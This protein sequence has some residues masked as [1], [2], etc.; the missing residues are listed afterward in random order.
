MSTIAEIE[1]AL[2]QLTDEDLL[3][4]GRALNRIYRERHNCTLYDDAYG[5][6]TEADLIAAA[7]EAFAAYDREEEQ[8]AKRSPR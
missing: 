2:A 3:R 7:D 1:A 5:V 8:H 6:Y 4:V